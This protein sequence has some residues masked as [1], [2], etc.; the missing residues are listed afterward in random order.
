MAV[1]ADIEEPMGPCVCVCVRAAS[2]RLLVPYQLQ[3]PQKYHKRFRV[4]VRSAQI[5]L[6]ALFLSPLILAA[7]TA[8]LQSKLTTH[9]GLRA[10]APPP[11]N[12][13]MHP[14][15]AYATAEVGN[16]P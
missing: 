10:H 7:A 14:Q 15:G 11:V 6:H 9:G 12:T 4:L 3:H 5:D 2:H 13:H 16:A 1:T 8:F